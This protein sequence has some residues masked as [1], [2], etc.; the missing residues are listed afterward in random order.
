MW[1]LASLRKSWRDSQT[2]HNRMVRCIAANKLETGL[3]HGSML[4]DLRGE[5]DTIK[6]YM[7]D[8]E[9]SVRLCEDCKGIDQRMHGAR[10]LP[11][12]G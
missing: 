5:I 1:R 8:E 3:R 4:F 9:L 7:G 2:T 10:F 12:P 6:D 11:L